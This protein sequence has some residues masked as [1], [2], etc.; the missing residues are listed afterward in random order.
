MKVTNPETGKKILVGGSIYNR[1]LRQG[2]CLDNNTY[3]L[4]KNKPE[5]LPEVVS[6]PTVNLGL[7]KYTFKTIVHLADIHF[8]G[9]MYDPAITEMYTIQFENLNAQLNN[10]DPKSTLIVIVGDI[11]HTGLNLE[12]DTIMYAKTKVKELA[13]KFPVLI[14]LIKVTEVCNWIY[15]IYLVG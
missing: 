10:L 6:V 5:N 3:E 4:V 15:L 8:K 7:E 12:S 13:D 1:L 2:Y 14:K 9:K 11:F